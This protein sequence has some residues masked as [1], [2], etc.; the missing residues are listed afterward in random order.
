MRQRRSTRSQE[1]SRKSTS[2]VRRGPDA[3]FYGSQTTTWY[4]KAMPPGGAGDARWI[5][6]VSSSIWRTENLTG[7]NPPATGLPMCRVSLRS[8][9]CN[10]G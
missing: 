1:S 9:G 2:S 7:G 8:P 6:A 3:A 10:R 4:S 5:T